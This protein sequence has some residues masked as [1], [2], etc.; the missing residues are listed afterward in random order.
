MLKVIPLLLLAIILTST[1]DAVVIGKREVNSVYDLPVPMTPDMQDFLKG[2]DDVVVD[3]NV[4]AY[5]EALNTSSTLAKRGFREHN[6]WPESEVNQARVWAKF[7]GASY[8]V[9]S[10]NVYDWN[11]GPHC[12]GGTEGTRVLKIFDTLLTATKGYIAVND[13]LKAIIL[14]FRGTLELPNFIKD[15]KLFKSPL[16]TPTSESGL[17]VHTGF[18]ETWE[19]VRDLVFEEIGKLLIQYK[20][21]DLHVTGHSLGGAIGLLATLALRHQFNIP[22]SRI[23]LH[24]FGQPRVGNPKF[25]D[26]VTRQKFRI[27]RV[28]HSNDLIP[29]L[30]PPFLDYKHHTLEY[31]QQ[32]SGKYYVCDK[33][34]PNE[35]K[36]C[37]NS[38][39]PFLNLLSHLVVFD[40]VIFGPW[41]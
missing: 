39:V 22:D 40:N 35:C 21:Y 6:N 8:C 24:T 38:R 4:T 10:K 20:D 3:L 27:S 14:S 5:N 12:K 13:R 17:Q 11:C 25:A 7:A 26:Y 18:Q 31:W 2:M 41:C 15:L 19:A 32:S 36:D 29:N 33:D 16:K 28:V 34:S 23:Q 37:S 9:L 1:V 30:I